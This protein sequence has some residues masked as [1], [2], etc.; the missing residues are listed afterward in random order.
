MKFALQE[1]CREGMRVEGCMSDGRRWGLVKI[2]TAKVRT[3]KRGNLRSEGRSSLS[4]EK[5]LLQILKGTQ[6][7]V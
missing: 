5:G 2:H 7:L 4:K 6:F 3:L 1:S